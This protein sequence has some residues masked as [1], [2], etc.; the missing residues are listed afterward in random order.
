VRAYIVGRTLYVD[1]EAYAVGCEI[2]NTPALFDK[3]PGSRRWTIRADSARP[4]TVSYMQRKGFRIIP[5]VKGPGSVEDGIEFLKSY[6]IVVHPR[7]R[8]TIDELT[9]YSFKVDS[10]TDEILPVLDDKNNHVIDA[11]RYACEGLRRAPKSKAPDAP[12]NPVDLWSRAKPAENG[13]KVI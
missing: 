10:K 1:Q 13:W 3:V 11:L 12:R 7:C 9:S 6:D 5:A 2:D 4:E 8:H